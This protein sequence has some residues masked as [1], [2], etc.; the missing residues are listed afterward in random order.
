MAAKRDYYEVLEITRTATREEIATSYRQLARKHHPDRNPGDADSITRFKEAAEAFEVLHDPQKRERYDRFGHAGVDG[1]GGGAHFTD[2]EDIFQAFGDIFG[3]GIF[4]DMFGGGRGGRRVRKGADLESEV[5]INLLEA[6]R[7]VTR[8]I[9]FRRHRRC[10]ECQGS[11]AA[12]GTQAETCRYCNGRGRVIQ[13]SGILRMQATC[14]SCR[15]T[16]QTIKER[17]RSCQG[18]GFSIEEVE[19]NVLIPRGIDDQM[20]IRISGEGEPSPDGGPPGD[21]YCLVHVTEHPL[22][23]R[24]GN[25]LIC[26]VPITFSQ[27][28]LGATIEVPTLDG[29]EELE[30]PAG[31]QPAEVFTL[32]RR[33]MPDPRGGRQI[34]DLLV[35]VNI[36]VPRKLDAR[37]EELIR[38]LAELESSHVSPHRKSFLEKLRGYFVPEENATPD[39]PVKDKKK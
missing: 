15:G 37:R 24:E 23:H 5:T 3:G 38:Q 26:R 13:S 8:P 22:F 10:D 18:E 35:Q 36:E 12:K 17:C 2:V 4:G 21:C 25:H 19:Q 1:P 20:R 32:K 16:G 39:K 31:T 27:A 30:V 7:G 28:A 33:G 34:G 11:G 14:P 9:R 29:P 6:A